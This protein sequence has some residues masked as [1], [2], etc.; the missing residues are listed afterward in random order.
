MEGRLGKALGFWVAS[1]TSKPQHVLYLQGEA[2]LGSFIGSVSTPR[3]GGRRTC[4]VLAVDAG[5]FGTQAF[6]SG[7]PLGRL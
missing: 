7:A 4:L 1:Q 2:S 3:L 6:A 5:G